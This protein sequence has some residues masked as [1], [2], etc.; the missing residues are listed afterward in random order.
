MSHFHICPQTVVFCLLYKTDH[1][2]FLHVCV[3]SIFCNKVRF[4]EAF[5]T[6]IINLIKCSA[7]GVSG[8]K[9]YLRRFNRFSA[10]WCVI[11]QCP[12]QISGWWMILL[13]P[14]AQP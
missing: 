1:I 11:L 5:L 10:L 8:A 2:K 9:Q 6:F 12:A 13:C 4:V 7:S 3:S 14:S